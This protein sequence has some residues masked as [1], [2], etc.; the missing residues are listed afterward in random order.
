MPT[1]ATTEIIF[2]GTV[3]T[4]AGGVIIITDVSQSNAGF[5]YDKLT[6][7]NNA[8]VTLSSGSPAYLYFNVSANIEAG[9]RVNIGAGT[10]TLFIIGGTLSTLFNINGTLDLQGQGIGNST[11][12]AFEP[13]TSFFGTGKT[14]VKGK[15]ILSGKVAVASM[16]N[17]ADFIVKNGGIFNVTRDGGTVPNGNYKNG[18]IGTAPVNW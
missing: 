12:T 6:V 15:F 8:T 17:P 14:T 4:L 1:A 10:G 11:R 3:S 9:S 7:I 5:S 18:S 2:D 16:S 13:L